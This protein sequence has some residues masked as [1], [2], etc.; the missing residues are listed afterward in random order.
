[1]ADNG[2]GEV[3]SS[4]DRKKNHKENHKSILK[5]KVDQA[6]NNL[7]T[8]LCRNEETGVLPLRRGYQAIRNVN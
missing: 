8:C 3:R 1:M 7:E 6:V 4:L 5:S 2:V